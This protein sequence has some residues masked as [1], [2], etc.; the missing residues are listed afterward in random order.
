MDGFRPQYT[1]ETTEEG[2]KD[3]FWE[4]LQNMV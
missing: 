4:E 3:V 2:R 1:S